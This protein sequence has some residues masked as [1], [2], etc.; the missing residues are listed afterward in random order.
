M[1]CRLSDQW[2]GAWPGGADAGDGGD[3]VERC[4]GPLTLGRHGARAIDSLKENVLRSREQRATL[5][6]GCPCA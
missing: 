3:F 1:K 4:V 6:S 5:M 2:S